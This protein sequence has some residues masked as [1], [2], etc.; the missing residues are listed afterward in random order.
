MHE[1]QREEERAGE[2]ETDRQTGTDR[3]TDRVGKLVFYAHSTAA[4]ISGR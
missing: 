3:E 2:K 4:V 1:Y